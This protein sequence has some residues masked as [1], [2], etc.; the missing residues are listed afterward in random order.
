MA[1]TPTAGELRHRVAF[2]ARVEQSDGY[3]NTKGA[4]QERCVVHAA[5][6]PRGGSEAVMAARLEGRNLIGVYVRASSAT[7]QITTEW[8]MRD[9]RVADP[10]TGD[11]LPGIKYNIVHVDAVTDRAWVYLDVQSGVA[12]G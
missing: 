12:A 11:D 9:V 1:K 3:G 6:R 2:D 10:T 4:W 7:R 8:R 5:F